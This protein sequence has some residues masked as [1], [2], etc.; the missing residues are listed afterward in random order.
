M[1]RQFFILI[2]C[3]IS[4]LSGT[5]QELRNGTFSS[6]SVAE[7]T[8]IGIM[9]ETSAFSVGFI[10]TL[11]GTD[12]NSQPSEPEPEPVP[13]P[14]PVPIP[15]HVTGVQLNRNEATMGIGETLLL[16]ANVYPTNADDKSV[17]W[18]SEDEV[19]VKVDNGMVTA[20]V[21]GN[22]V[23]TVQTVD[24]N[25]RAS[26]NVTVTDPTAIEDFESE[27]I[28]LEHS[29]LHLDLQEAQFVR[30]V[31][32]SG[33][34]IKAVSCLAGENRISMFDCAA[35]IYYVCLKNKTVGIVKR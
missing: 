26:C 33:Q 29:I 21:V 17:H 3:T 7:P 2:L 8:L 5:A 19:V 10:E 1:R 4:Y 18:I 31:N 22:T 30:I 9:G 28:Y 25:F 20:L 34:V 35:G 27:R 13:D 6:L 14:E 11:L 16:Q 23:I 32:V 15:I 12:N 24:G